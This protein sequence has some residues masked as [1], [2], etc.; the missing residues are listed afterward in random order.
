[1]PRLKSRV[2][3]TIPEHIDGPTEYAVLY[4]LSS[5]NFDAIDCAN[6]WANTEWNARES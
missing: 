4:I 2:V 3:K 1:M 5:D 6:V